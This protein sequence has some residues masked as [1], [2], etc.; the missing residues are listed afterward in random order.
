[1]SELSELVEYTKD[2]DHFQLPIVGNVGIHGGFVIALA[3]KSTS[4]VICTIWQ[5]HGHG[6][7]T[8]SSVQKCRN[9][10]N[11]RGIPTI[12]N[13]P[14]SEISE[15]TKDSS[16]FWHTESTCVI[17]MIWQPHGHGTDIPSSVQKCRN[18]RNCQNIRRIPTIFNDP[19]SEMSE[20]TEGSPVFWYT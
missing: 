6:A 15:Y 10:R 14:L 13:D 17:C 5:T 16:A 12:S 2:S 1:M 9:C 20:Y 7:D 19:L 11:Q 8:P 4:C 18:C 3:H